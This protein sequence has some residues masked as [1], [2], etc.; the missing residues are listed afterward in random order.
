MRT[1]TFSISVLFTRALSDRMMASLFITP[2]F[3]LIF[4]AFLSCIHHRYICHSSDFTARSLS[5][6]FYG[7][8]GCSYHHLFRFLSISHLN[9]LLQDIL[10]IFFYLWAYQYLTF[11]FC[12]PEIFSFSKDISFKIVSQIWRKLS[13]KIFNLIIFLYGVIFLRFERVNS[14]IIHWKIDFVI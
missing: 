7:F 13:G 4:L 14:I 5:N 1:R 8:R 6:L 11:A 2:N 9:S 12:G 10:L 3:L